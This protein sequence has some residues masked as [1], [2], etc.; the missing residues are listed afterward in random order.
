MRLSSYTAQQAKRYILDPLTAPEPSQETGPGSSFFNPSRSLSYRA[1]EPPPK[2]GRRGQNGYPTPPQSASP[3]R[4]TFHPSNPFSRVSDQAPL[5]PQFDWAPA[6]TI[7]ARK[8]SFDSESSGTNLPTP[9]ERFPPAIRDGH[10]PRALEQLSRRSFDQQSSE[11]SGPYLHERLSRRASEKLPLRVPEKL[12]PQSPERRS[13]DWRPRSPNGGRSGAVRYPPQTHHTQGSADVVETGGLLSRSASF[14]GNGLGRSNSLSQRYPGDLSHRP[15]DMLKR[16]NRAADRAPHRR[17]RTGP[18]TDTIDSLDRSAVGGLFHHGGP[19]D[20]TLASRNTNKLYS[21]VEAVKESNFEALRATPSEYIQDSLL[22]HV[23]LQGVATVPPGM[24][25]M[26][27][28]VMKY[29]EGADLMREPDAPGGAY[30]RWD[31]IVSAYITTS[32]SCEMCEPVSNLLSSP[33]PYQPGDLKGKG[34]P[35]PPAEQSPKE[36]KRI[37]RQPASISA[38]YDMKPLPPSPPSGRKDGRTTVRQRSIS[39]AASQGP[40]LSHASLRLVNP[41]SPRPAEGVST[42]NDLHRRN[43]TGNRFTEGLMRRFGSLRRKRSTAA[44]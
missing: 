44:A 5:L 36:Q 25:D 24:A 18:T 8:N 20:A 26:K 14:S 38:E 42:T 3:S 22:K 1:K 34:E 32:T 30:R 27:G 43:T 12:A 15:L 35:S 23:P 19:Y 41:V 11:R 7:L 33:Q 6:S 10:K 4:T 29:E 39:G 17:R 13:P 40:P 16:E 31:F 28:K 9:P 2:R 21:P 37:R